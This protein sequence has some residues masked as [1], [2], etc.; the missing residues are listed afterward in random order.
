MDGIE[1]RPVY[2]TTWRTRKTARTIA[3]ATAVLL[4]AVTLPALPFSAATSPPA[5]MFDHLGGNEYW[6]EVKVTSSH[7]INVVEVRA[8]NDR[9]HG[10]STASW[11]P[12]GST[13]VSGIHIPPG[14]PV[15]FA[16][17]LDGF[18]AQSCFYSHP[19]GVERCDINM[20]PATANFRAPSGNEWWQQVFVDSNRDI[21][22][23]EA[24][25][26]GG[27]TGGGY[28]EKRS[29]GAWAGSFHAPRGSV[30]QFLAMTDTNEAFSSACYSWPDVT[31]VPCK[32]PIVFDPSKTRFDHITGNEWWVEVTLTGHQPDG[33]IARDDGGPW[34]ALEYKSWGAWAGSFRIEPGHNVQFRFAAGDTLWDS[35]VFTH[36]AGLAPSGDQTCGTTAVGQSQPFF[37]H[38]T[39][40]E[41][42]VE[43]TV[44]HTEPNWV[45]ASDDGGAT[46][47]ALTKRSWGAWA[48][49]FHIEPGNKVMFRAD[50]VGTTY[51]SCQFSH[52]DGFAEGMGPTHKHCNGSTFF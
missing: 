50:V 23:V 38:K 28:L 6:V 41:W 4:L 3:A 37:T 35:C 46:W 12:S 5:V 7:P 51:Q 42:W 40:N 1:T 17:H 26:D 43:V 34:V 13:Y 31:V 14:T 30:V 48:G 21:I 52:P 29:W 36:P 33:V 32:E 44:Q 25:I 47:H 20:P 39:G 15:Q 24:M 27:P 18:T 16:A 45:L 8:L 22:A 19:A 2:N 10:M 11:D 9:W 49:S